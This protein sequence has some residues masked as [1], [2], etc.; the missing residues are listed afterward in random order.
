MFQVLRD[1]KL[2]AKREKCAFGQTK[3]EYL[4][5][6]IQGNGVATDPVKVE[7][8]AKWPVPQNISE[9]RSILGMAG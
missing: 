4:G 8:I 1:N 2:A 5:H 3:V 6:I 7:V 9:L